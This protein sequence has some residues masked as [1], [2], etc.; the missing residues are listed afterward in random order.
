M[1]NNTINASS[2]QYGVLSKSASGFTTISPSMTSGYALSSNGLSSESSF[3]AMA[4]GKSLV[5]L[6]TQTASSSASLVFDNIETGYP[7]Y[8]ISWEN[9]VV[10]TPTASLYMQV[11]DDNGSTYSSSNNVGLNYFFYS[12]S[13]YTNVLSTS[14]IAL[15]TGI[16]E[17]AGANGYCYLF[18]IHTAN[19]FN[20]IGQCVWFNSD[21]NTSLGFIGGNVGT[22]EIDSFRIYASTGN[23]TSGIFSLYGVLDS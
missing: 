8:F 1:K 14:Q 9:I 18:N 16:S 19:N 2:S 13:T 15:S 4:L 6:E 10:S 17:D 23:L 11:S 22:S 12:S 7:I 5:P 20:M 3:N 21:G